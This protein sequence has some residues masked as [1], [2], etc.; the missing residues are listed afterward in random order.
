[1]PVVGAAPWASPP[2][3][4]AR[5]TS[6]YRRKLLSRRRW[7]AE[8]RK[9]G[10][11]IREALHLRQTSSTNESFK[12]YESRGT[13]DPSASAASRVAESV[14]LDTNPRFH[15]VKTF[16][17]GLRPRSADPRLSWSLYARSAK[18]AR[19]NYLFLNLLNEQSVSRI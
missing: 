9:P 11:A 10:L 7:S 4:P 8:H 1:M 18:H 12:I 15:P 19:I 3:R 17:L 2:A 14:R 16:P 5:L 13:N 6:P